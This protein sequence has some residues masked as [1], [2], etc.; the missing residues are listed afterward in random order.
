MASRVNTKLVVVLVVGVVAVCAV[1]IGLYS[2]VLNRGPEDNVRE[3]D[4]AMAAGEP[5]IARSMYGRAV[6]KDPHNVE[7]LNKWRGAIEAWRPETETAFNNEFSAAW[8]PLLRALAYAQPENLDASDEYLNL[9]YRLAE[10]GGF[11]PSAVSDLDLET[12]ALLAM[13]SAKSPNDLGRDRLRRYRAL[14]RIDLMRNNK[15]V[16]ALEREEAGKDLQA[17]IDVDSEDGQASVGLS[18]LEQ[19]IA[20]DELRASRWNGFEEHLDI[21]R[22]ILSDHLKADPDDPSV[23]QTQFEL[24]LDYEYQKASRGKVGA[25]LQV[26]GGEVADL[27]VPR[28][29]DLYN[30]LVNSGDP[31]DVRLLQRF[32]RVERMVDSEAKGRRT[33]SL[34]DKLVAERPDDAAILMFKARELKDIGDFEGSVEVLEELAAL[35]S[36]PVGIDGMMQIRRQRQAYWELAEI[37]LAETKALESSD[38]TEKAELL[39]RAR[40]YRDAYAQR[41]AK[42]DLQLLFLDALIS[43]A[44]G[45]FREALTQFQQFNQLLGSP[46]S[47]IGMR[48]LWSA[49]QI[50]AR[51]GEHGRARE[52]FKK[53]ITIDPNR[54]RAMVALA[55]TERAL[56]NPQEALELYKRA[57]RLLPGNAFVDDQIRKLEVELGHASS[58]DPVEQALADARQAFAG[59]ADEAGRPADAIDILKSA[60]AANGYAPA[61]ARE[62]ATMYLYSKDLASARDVI[63]KSFEANP[64][65]ESLG[66][67]LTALQQ[68]T[69]LD[70]Q[71]SMIE[72]SSLT[73]EQKYTN[74]YQIYLN[75]GETDLAREALGK[76]AAVAPESQR[77]IDL[78][79]VD[80]LSQGDMDKA[81]EIYETADELGVLGNDSLTYRARLE[82]MEGRTQ[83]A[84]NT[85]TQAIE[86]GVSRAPVYRL[87]GTQLQ[88]AG[89][90]QR[91]LA[92]F[93]QAYQ[94]KPDD[95]G[96]ALS[97]A[98]MLWVMGEQEKALEIARDSERFG[99]SNTEFMN[100]WLQLEAAAGGE[101]GLARAVTVREQI[102]RVRPEDRENRVML[103]QLYIDAASD[104]SSALSDQMR[105]E[106]WEKSKLLIDA[107]KEEESNLQTVILEARWLADQGRV[108]QEDGTTIDGVEAARGVFIEYIIGLGDDATVTPYIEL[109]RFMSARGR[110][111]VA[112]SSL[113]GAREYQSEKMEVEKVLGGLYLQTKA[114]RSAAES[115]RTVVDAG[116]DDEQRNYLIRLVEMYLKMGDYE[117]A[118]DRLATVPESMSE[119]Q[120]VILQRAEAADGSG[121]SAEAARLFDRAVALYSESPLPYARRAEFRLRNPEMIQ[122]VLADLGQA[123]AIDPKNVQ[124]LQLRASVYGQLKRYEDML[125]DL[126]TALRASPDSSNILVSVML[127][128]LMKGDDGRAMDIVEETLSKRP[129]DLMLIALSA[130]VFEDR[131]YWE[132]A[133]ELFKRGWEMSGN[134]AFGLAYINTLIEQ[135]PPK[136][137]EAERVMRQIRTLTGAAEKDWQVDFADAAIKYKKG[138]REKAEQMLI[139]IYD[140]IVENP[141]ELSRWRGDIMGLYRDDPASRNDFFG[142][143]VAS[144]AEGSLGQMWAKFFLASSLSDSEET[145]GEAV[146]M[147][148]AMEA[149]GDSSAFARFAFRQHGGMEYADGNFEEAVDVWSRGLDVFPGD[150]E[151]S[152]NSAFALATELNRP[153]DALPFALSAVEAA[154]QQAE[155]YDSLARVYIGIGELE[156]ASEALE[157]ARR[158]SR[159]KRSEVSV[160]VTQAELDINRG[161]TAG[162]R[163][164]LERL[165]LGIS[166]IPDLRDDFESDIELL[167]RKI[168][169]LGE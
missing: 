76:A 27:F 40:E 16:S 29:D 68:D 123:L 53:M 33:H 95:I 112:E 84:I 52:S 60:I 104:S 166:L 88:A 83:E 19:F 4:K 101:E 126:T 35:E 64:E 87:L 110:Y 111:G 41:V 26:V 78:R 131:K 57:S 151:M 79:F 159:S 8:I 73:E 38:E 164:S 134:H 59:S 163:R 122:D 107:L 37:A 119:N 135:D 114:Y 1:G 91:A 89:L 15:Q 6:N 44:S 158:Y 144:H 156:K 34:I 77:V 147:F 56:Q 136:V 118:R 46:S 125:T 32:S 36:K 7:W 49:G 17:V 152:N 70:A 3:G 130:K 102:L 113:K 85:L 67:L 99:R 105:K 5:G 120:T 149:L 109:A 65:E 30:G 31:L 160:M 20:K 94:I 13:I 97:L 75:A 14:A 148:E 93:E 98:R 137:R 58:D 117:Q 66:N 81:R 86:L 39:D 116:Q 154:P 62:L 54:A 51:L 12:A 100:V 80:A 138:D 157:K 25:A 28:L 10:G 133:A 21:A 2:F 168:D 47:S 11:S 96:N 146:E 161:K 150:W 124:T 145:R 108:P 121:D 115:F 48:G 61:L 74:I 127:E 69:M 169:S 140:L 45:D 162:A 143:I 90:Y 129:R 23:L 18:L 92:A 9:L 42:D 153:E 141:N 24:E 165:L 155:A 72:L 106:S 43:E 82:A 142:S 63:S 22:K 50:A 128:Y 55:T 103:T 139:E 167:L 71:I 132:R